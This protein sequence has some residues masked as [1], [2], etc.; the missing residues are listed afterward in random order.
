MIAVVASAMAVMG[1]LMEAKKEEDNLVSKVKDPFHPVELY[2]NDPR[3]LNQVSNPWLAGFKQPRVTFEGDHKHNPIPELN[4]YNGGLGKDS[5]RKLKHMHMMLLRDQLGNE[6]DP[7]LSDEAY[8]SSNP[9]KGDGA[10]YSIDYQTWLRSVIADR[11][12]ARAIK[13]Q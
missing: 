11:E 4:E 13:N 10:F 3:V 8:I 2:E 7:R 12:E 1:I 6:E 9:I 5:R